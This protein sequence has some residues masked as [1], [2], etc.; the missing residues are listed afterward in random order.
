MLCGLRLCRNV[1]SLPTVAKPG[2][3]VH[4]SG[5]AQ[6]DPSFPL[7]VCRRAATPESRAR[8]RAGGC[9]SLRGQCQRGTAVPAKEQSRCLWQG[10]AP[11]LAPPILV[12]RAAARRGCW[13]HTRRVGLVRLPSAA[14][15][16]E[17]RNFI[18]PFCWC[19]KLNLTIVLARPFGTSVSWISFPSLC[20]V[21]SPGESTEFRRQSRTH[22]FKP[23]SVPKT[24]WICCQ[25]E[26]CTC[27]LINHPA[28][29]LG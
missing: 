4:L 24:R 17:V 16:H 11:L 6:N 25:S 3:A 22:R 28:L 29:N 20:S 23:A 9:R 2:R 26:P 7:P 14:P 15:P 5:K 12:L 19:L 21:I 13:D 10:P 1:V 8:P 18:H 27:H